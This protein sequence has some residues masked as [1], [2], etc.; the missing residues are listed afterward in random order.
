MREDEA[1]AVVAKLQTLGVRASVARL[2]VYRTGIRVR[3]GDGREALW[4][5]DGA[6][7]LEA[8]VMRDGNLV[9][10][11]PKIPGSADFDVAQQAAAIAAVDYESAP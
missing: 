6:A 7:G 9:G 2:G 5:V 3:L 1:T 10:F 4:D 11:V 8:Q